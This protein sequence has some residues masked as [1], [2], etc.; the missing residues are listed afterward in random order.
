MNEIEPMTAERFAALWKSADSPGAGAEQTLAEA[1]APG[2][3]T[4][5]QILILALSLRDQVR[6]GRQ[7]AG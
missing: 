3:E 5:L 1:N 7:S 2:R 6:K 4:R